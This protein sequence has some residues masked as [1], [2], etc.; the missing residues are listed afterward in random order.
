[1][2]LF[3]LLILRTLFYRTQFAGM[4]GTS[5]SLM[6]IKNI[7]CVGVTTTHGITVIYGTL[8]FPNTF[9]HKT[10]HETGNFKCVF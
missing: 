4:L 6:I 7:H 10:T 5:N 2:V 1:M 9:I 8:P 3:L